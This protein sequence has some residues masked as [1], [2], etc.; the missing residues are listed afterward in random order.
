MHRG[1]SV[2]VRAQWM[3]QELFQFFAP[4]PSQIELDPLEAVFVRMGP[5]A[6]PEPADLSV[7][8]GPVPAARLEAAE[9]A[10]FV[11]GDPESD[12]FGVLNDRSGSVVADKGREIP[13]GG[14]GGFLGR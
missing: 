10:G 9:A 6:G 1:C 13:D 12:E 11:P 7:D 14:E 8:G 3:L 5:E 2:W 4:G